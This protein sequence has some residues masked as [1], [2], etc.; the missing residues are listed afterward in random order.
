MGALFG[1]GGPPT[2]PPAPAVPIIDT[3]PTPMPVPDPDEEKRSALKK[4]AVTQARQTTRASTI[5]G[6]SSDTLG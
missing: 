5:I 6:D 4:M 2:P 3:T 1:G